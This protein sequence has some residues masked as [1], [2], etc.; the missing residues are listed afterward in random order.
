M[1]ADYGRDLKSWAK[2]RDRAL[3]GF[4]LCSDG[5]L[6][7]PMLC[8]EAVKAFD[9]RLASDKRRAADRERLKAWREARRKG[10][11]AGDGNGVGNGLETPGETGGD[12]PDETDGETRFVVR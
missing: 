7:H 4:V 12:T 5:R 6:Y 1:L 3:H 8:R 9:F 10:E 2:I 11:Q